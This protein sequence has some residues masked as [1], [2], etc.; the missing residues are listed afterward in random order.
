MDHGGDYMVVVEVVVEENAASSIVLLFLHYTLSLI[1]SLPFP[2]LPLSL[3]PFLPPSLS[4]VCCCGQATERATQPHSNEHGGGKVQ[5]QYSCCLLCLSLSLLFLALALSRSLSFWLFFS[6][7][8]LTSL[9]SLSLVSKVITPMLVCLLA[10]GS[11]VVRMN[12]LSALLLES[13]D[14]LSNVL[15]GLIGRRALTMPFDRSISLDLP[16]CRVVL[17]VLTHEMH[18]RQFCPCCS[19]RATT[20]SPA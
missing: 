18:T 11:R 8:S 5:G 9:L 7:L 13:C 1:H 3:S 2:S 20:K 17:R 4:L 15:G 6:Y 12:I 14:Y 19:S 10:D 16:R